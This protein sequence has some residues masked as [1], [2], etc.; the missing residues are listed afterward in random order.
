MANI[1]TQCE[2]GV[3]NVDC[4]AELVN[5]EVRLSELVG[6]FRH[7]FSKGF[8]FFPLLSLVFVKLSSDCNKLC[9]DYHA[10]VDPFHSLLLVMKLL[11]N[12]KVVVDVCDDA[13]L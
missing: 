12:F 13:L 6:P 2:N 8:M 7:D 4:L 5:L 10:L 1:S 9:F 3:G 11:F